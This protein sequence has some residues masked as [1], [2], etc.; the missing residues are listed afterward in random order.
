MKIHNIQNIK[1]QDNEFY[2][3]LFRHEILCSIISDFDINN[4]IHTINENINC[5]CLVY[6]DNDELH[7]VGYCYDNKK[8]LQFSS[9]NLNKD[10]IDLVVYNLQLDSALIDIESSTDIELFYR[11]SCFNIVNNTCEISSEYVKSLNYNDTINSVKLNPISTTKDAKRVSEI[12]A[13]LTIMINT[14][15][16]QHKRENAAIGMYGE[17]YKTEMS[18][19][20]SSII[21]QG[22]KLKADKKALF[23]DIV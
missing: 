20:I 7:T 11:L 19:F 23:I 5:V 10:L 2:T 6:D 1:E 18:N 21:E 13:K 8:Y 12:D 16:P 17:D 9:I 3:L 15:Y 14:K 22:K 4:F